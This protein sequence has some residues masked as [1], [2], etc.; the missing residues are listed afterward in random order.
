MNLRS[1]RDR[2]SV[3]LLLVSTFLLGAANCFS[4]S[5][6]VESTLVDKLSKFTIDR[7]QVVPQADHQVS[8]QVDG[9]E[10]LRWNF[11]DHHPKPFFFP[12]NGP[13]G[14]SLTRLGHPGAPDHDHHL[15]VWFAHR[16]IGGQN[17]W[18]G[19][20]KARIAQTNWLAYQDG[21]DAATIA[22]D[23]E[24]RRDDETPI[25]KQRLVASL[26][27]LADGECSLELQIT[28]STPP[29][30]DEVLLGKTKFWFAGRTCC[31]GA[32]GFIR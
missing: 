28:L 9:M 4:Q 14:R 30:A 32:I 26:S 3:V 23:C 25:L 20:G 6:G 15:S 5:T 8:L 29:G 22:V 11:G 1:Y 7:C 10:Q 21:D 2:S 18:D 19:S 27:P 12:L 13:S 16:D 24:W 31:Q 17:F